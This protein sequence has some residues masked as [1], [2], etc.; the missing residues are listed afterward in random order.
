MQTHDRGNSVTLV[1]S[2]AAATKPQI[3]LMDKLSP[4][5]TDKYDLISLTPFFLVIR[6]HNHREVEGGR[7]VNAG[8]SLSAALCCE[9]ILLRFIPL[10]VRFGARDK[11]CDDSLKHSMYKTSM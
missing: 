6:R 5:L 8:E 1:K 10:H 2:N 9:E 3:Q 7:V 11:N 4:N